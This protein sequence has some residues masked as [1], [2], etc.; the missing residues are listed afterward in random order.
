MH[1][2]SKIFVAF[3]ALT[4]LGGSALA[5]TPPSPTPPAK[6]GFLHNLF[7]HP[8][9]APVQPMGRPIRP[10]DARPYD[11]GSLHDG[12]SHDA[13]SFHDGRG[14]RQ[15]KHARLP[16]ARRQGRTARAAEPRYFH[17]AAQ[18]MA[19]GYHRAGG[20]S[21]SGHPMMHGSPMHGMPMHGTTH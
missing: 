12:Q 13:G 2:T 17:T 15:Q 20:S 5:Q 7:H 3:A 19:A 10:H 1:K 6:H 16:P 4:A 8:K 18:A 21:M 9:P 14:Y 11:A